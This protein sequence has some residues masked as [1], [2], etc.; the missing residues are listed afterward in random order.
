MN[1]MS[2]RT[3]EAHYLPNWRLTQ[4]YGLTGYN[5]GYAAARGCESFNGHQQSLVWRLIGDVPIEPDSTVLDV[6]CGIGGPAGWIAERYRPRR[7]IGVEYLWSSVSAAE[8]RASGESHAG[9]NQDRANE[10]HRPIFVQGDAHRLPLADASIDVIFNLES[11]LHYLDKRTFIV[12]CRRVLKPGGVLCLGDITTRYKWLFAPAQW[13]NHL[14][15][16]FN[17]NVWLWSPQDYRRAFEAESFELL[18]HEEVSRPVADSLT[19]G[20]A[21]I[22]SRGLVIAKGY[23]GR[24]FYL[25]LLE[26]LLRGGLLHYD[27]FTL[28]RSR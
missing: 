22:T 16:Q 9:G 4:A 10:N 17:S 28:R 7:L 1:P 3:L 25:A 8:T 26:K 21:E 15:S 14:P 27:L 13:L 20:I 24:F 11:A 19:D 12:E 5:C 2:L 18:R 6:G 23:R